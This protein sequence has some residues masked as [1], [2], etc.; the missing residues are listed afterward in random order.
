MFNFQN[1][2]ITYTPYNTTQSDYTNR[3]AMDS[4][5]EVGIA[6]D[7]ELLNGNR[8]PGSQETLLDN[9]PEETQTPLVTLATSPDKLVKLNEACYQGPP[10]QAAETQKEAD[11][12]NPPGNKT[13]HE[14]PSVDSRD[15]ELPG[16]KVTLATG[17][18]FSQSDESINE[19]NQ[20]AYGY[21]NQSEYRSVVQDPKPVYH[22]RPKR[23]S[24]IAHGH[25]RPWSEY[26]SEEHGISRSTSVDN[27]HLPVSNRSSNPSP[28][29][30]YKP[31]SILK[32]CHTAPGQYGIQQRP[33]FI[34]DN[35]DTNTNYN[36]NVG[37]DSLTNKIGK[38]TKSPT[39]NTTQSIPNCD[40]TMVL[41]ND[42]LEEDSSPPS[43]NRGNNVTISSR[44]TREDIRNRNAPSD[45]NVNKTLDIRNAEHSGGEESEG[46]GEDDLLSDNLTAGQRKFLLDPAFEGVEPTYV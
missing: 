16:I 8:T 15:V 28:G 1:E 12:D 33:S 34:M 5:D 32:R 14:T 22:R 25:Y 40:N 2:C 42:I 46:E 23:C 35:K 38:H 17:T 44:V 3:V 13:S 27:P 4:D 11:S 26:D 6:T 9:T 37:S 39:G 43:N 30:N 10:L 21:S 36:N 29:S 7:E 18:G 31:K 41:F 20:V 19:H 45:G 24:F